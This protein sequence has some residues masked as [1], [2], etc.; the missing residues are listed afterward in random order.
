MQ[1]IDEL[2]AT[3]QGARE[4]DALVLRPGLFASPAAQGLVRGRPEQRLALRGVRIVGPSETPGS[5]TLHGTAAEAWAV[6]GVGAGA[7]AEVEVE[8][9]FRAAADGPPSVSGTVRGSLRLGDMPLPVEGILT[10]DGSLAL[11]VAAGALPARSL[12]AWSRLA[13]AAPAPGSFPRPWATRGSYPPP[14][15]R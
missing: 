3:L 8:L 4:G 7:L 6:P 2:Y 10:D 11:R 14:R 13:G 12:E 5:L 15:S 1:T 9:T